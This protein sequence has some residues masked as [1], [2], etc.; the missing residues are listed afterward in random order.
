MAESAVGGGEFANL[1]KKTKGTSW[2]TYPTW[3]R[4]GRDRLKLDE[5]WNFAPPRP[6]LPTCSTV[7]VRAKE[8]SA[9]PAVQCYNG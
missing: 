7:K 2:K 6:E 5:L 8:T 4:E 9:G 1:P 3:E